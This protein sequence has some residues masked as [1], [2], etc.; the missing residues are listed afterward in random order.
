MSGQR[1]P[2][3]TYD[4]RLRE[5][6]RETGDLTVAT[7]LGVPRS[8]ARPLLRRERDRLIAGRGQKKLAQTLRRMPSSL[9][10]IRMGPATHGHG[11]WLTVMACGSRSPYRSSPWRA[12]GPDRHDLTPVTALWDPSRVAAAF[13]LPTRHGLLNSYSLEPVA[14]A[15]QSSAL[16]GPWRCELG[17]SPGASPHPAK[18]TRVLR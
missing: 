7:G 6:V 1:R 9:R 8:T 4:H 13:A 5:L 10:R 16:S 2:Q 18:Q 12:R 11:L 3:R 15:A 14:E 17:A